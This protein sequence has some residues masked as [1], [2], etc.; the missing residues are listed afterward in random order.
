MADLS[1]TA[2]AFVGVG[3][4]LGFGLLILAKVKTAIQETD[5]VNVTSLAYNA[6]GDA[7]EAMGNFSGWLPLL[8]IVIVAGIILWY[9]RSSMGGGQGGASL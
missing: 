1:S 9:V 2:L 3:I 8:A 6:T 4:I 5:G 7:E